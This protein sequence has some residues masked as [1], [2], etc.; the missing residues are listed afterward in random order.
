M[1]WS[2][3][4][5]C[6]DAFFLVRAFQGGGLL[7]VMDVV[8]LVIVFD[9]AH[10]YHIGTPIELSSLQLHGV[11]ALTCVI[12]Y[13][14]D[15][16]RV[17]YN[18]P[19]FSYPVQGVVAV[20]VA[21][22]VLAAIVYVLPEQTRASSRDTIY[23]RGVLVVAMVWFAVWVAFSRF[24]LSAIYARLATVQPWLVIGDPDVT[25][26]VRDDFHRVRLGECL[27]EM[28]LQGLEKDIVPGELN[29]SSG[30]RF[31]FTNSDFAG[32]GADRLGDTPR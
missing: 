10:R 26:Q 11:V 16:Y 9:M 12:L 27:V 32:D 29:M 18:F 21:G 1:K 23:W 2:L 14:M 31:L 5:C 25:K 24:I 13:I 22:L 15:L 30:Y 8:V 20:G 17:D 19:S 3:G 6:S 4:P 28:P 7:L